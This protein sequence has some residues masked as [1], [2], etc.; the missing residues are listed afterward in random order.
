MTTEWPLPGSVGFA[1]SNGLFGKLIRLGEWL[2]FRNGD[3]WNH[4][5]VVS[6][7]SLNGVPYVIQ[8]EAKGV[9][10]DK[11]ITTVA[12]GGTY[13]IVELPANVDRTKTLE[14]AKGEVG[15]EYGWLSIVDIAAKII[16]PKWV[17]FPSI[18]SVQTWIC[19][20]LGAE[21]MRY[22]GWLHRW[23][24]IYLVVPSEH[25]A[26]L[27]NVGVR[28]VSQHMRLAANQ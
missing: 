9:T 26:A 27:T 6:D 13:Q 17:P 22:A 2:R 12:P 19:S 14:F 18:Q 3:F 16:L 8:A 20:T 25:Y 10:D 23:P 24:N 4:E 28:Q 1:H 7:K 11:L 21:A 15:T 5:F